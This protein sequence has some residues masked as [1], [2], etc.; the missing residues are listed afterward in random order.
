MT[1][2]VCILQAVIFFASDLESGPVF[3]GERSEGSVKSTDF[4]AQESGGKN[5]ADR[6]VASKKI[7]IFF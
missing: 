7:F 2:S 1:L 5:D 6:D 3:G 4:R